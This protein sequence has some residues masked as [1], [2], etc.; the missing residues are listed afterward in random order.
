MHHAKIYRIYCAF[1]TE[2]NHV[3]DPEKIGICLGS[4]SNDSR[5][6]SGRFH[7]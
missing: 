3:R 4:G 2:T 6:A 5:F 7:V 1:K